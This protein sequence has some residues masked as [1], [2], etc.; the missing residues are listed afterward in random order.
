MEFFWNFFRILKKIR[1]GFY[2]FGN[3]FEN[4]FGNSFGATLLSQ[5]VCSSSRTSFN[6]VVFAEEYTTAA[7][8]E[9]A[10]DE[11]ILM[12]LTITMIKAKTYIGKK[13][14]RCLI[15]CM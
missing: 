4:S 6:V 10:S 13:K 3:S 15:L 11:P 5:E 2:L 1:L 9:K 14:T 12:E 7:V 8:V